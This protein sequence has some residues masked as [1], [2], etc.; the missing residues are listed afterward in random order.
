M[1]KYSAVKS[2]ERK[3]S[4]NWKKILPR[5]PGFLGKNFST[6]EVKRKT[7]EKKKKVVLG[8]NPR[9]LCNKVKNGNARGEW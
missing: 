5:K 3:K 2:S 7:R 1:K 6:D 8:K 4:E 9:D